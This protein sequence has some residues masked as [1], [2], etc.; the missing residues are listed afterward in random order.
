[1]IYCELFFRF[2]KQAKGRL[3]DFDSKIRFYARKLEFDLVQQKID[4]D[5]E[6]QGTNILENWTGNMGI[7]K[8]MVSPRASER[9]SASELL[10]SW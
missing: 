7:L 5:E 2:R 6:L 10:V 8:S 1:M 4:L 3:G 9:M